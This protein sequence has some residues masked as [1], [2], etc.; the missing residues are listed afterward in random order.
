MME[1][2]VKQEKLAKARIEKAK[3]VFIEMFG[4]EPM[5]YGHVYEYADL[6]EESISSGEPKLMEHDPSIFL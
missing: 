4:Y 5:F 3:P 6:L 2:Q 1:S